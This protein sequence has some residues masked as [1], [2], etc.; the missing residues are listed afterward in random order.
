MSPSG[1]VSVTLNSTAVEWLAEGTDGERGVTF[2]LVL[3]AH[4]EP[5]LRDVTK[6]LEEGDSVVTDVTYKTNSSLPE[7]TPRKQVIEVQCT[8]D[9]WTEPGILRAADKWDALFWTESSIKKFL[10]PYYHSHRFWDKK[11]EDFER[12]FDT[13]PEAVAIAHVAPSRSNR[14]KPGVN[15]LG[16]VTPDPSAA[17]PGNI[18]SAEEYLRRRKKR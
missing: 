9:T 17:L 8:V 10:Y 11:M 6:Q 14:L 16:V 4:K 18:I 13:D 2:I 7:S 12:E 15:T 5:Q 3:D 1:P